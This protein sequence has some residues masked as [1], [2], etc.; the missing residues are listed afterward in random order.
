MVGVYIIALLGGTLIMFVMKKCN[1]YPHF[2]ALGICIR[3]CRHFY[4]EDSKCI[5]MLD[6]PEHY[7]LMYA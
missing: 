1:L 6:T 4:L 5:S 2:S 7:V 3:Q